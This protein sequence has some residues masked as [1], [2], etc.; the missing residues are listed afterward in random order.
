[1]KKLNTAMSMFLSTMSNNNYKTLWELAKK[2]TRNG[3]LI[4]KMMMRTLMTI[5][6]LMI[7]VNAQNTLEITSMVLNPASIPIKRI[8]VRWKNL[9]ARSLSF[10]RVKN[11]MAHARKPSLNGKSLWKISKK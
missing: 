2:Q 8:F 5:A 9:L 10:Q 1:M 3:A 4:T 6:S 7:R 11:G